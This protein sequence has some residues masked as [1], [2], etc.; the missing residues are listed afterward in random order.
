MANWQRTLKLQPE[1]RMAQEGEITHQALAGV[2][3]ARLAALQPFGEGVGRT[4]M[5]FDDERQ[6]IADGFEALSEDDS[7]TRE[8]FDWMMSDLYDWADQSMDSKWNGKKVCWV[9]T[10]GGVS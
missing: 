9:D 2:I 4:M 6:D 5:D 3:A 7:A 10:I 1:W 8:H